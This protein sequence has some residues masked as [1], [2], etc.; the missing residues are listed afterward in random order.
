ME[1]GQTNFIS[2]T[3]EAR[4]VLCRL[5]FHYVP[6]HAS[7]LTWWRLRS[8]CQCLDRRIGSIERLTAQTAAW[9]QQRYAA[10]ARIKWMFTTGKARAKMARACPQPQANSRHDQNLCERY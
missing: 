8:A 7:W 4:R 3:D 10:R 2:P 5:E 9:E 1:A 6:K